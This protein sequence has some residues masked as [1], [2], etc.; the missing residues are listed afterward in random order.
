MPGR[1][2][3]RPW[4]RWPAC[5]GTAGGPP[6]RM[7]RMPAA[8]HPDLAELTALRD[9]CTRFLRGHGP[10]RA[11]DLLAT[12]PPDTAPDHYGDAGVVA[13]LEGEI[14]LLLG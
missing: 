5:P 9:Q 1:R 10:V 7:S 8:D 13:D 3:A 11:A 12:V 6:G 14:A 2:A 4:H